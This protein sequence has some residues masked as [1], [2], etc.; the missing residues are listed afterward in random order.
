MPCSVWNQLTLPRTVERMSVQHQMPGAKVKPILLL[1]LELKVSLF[2]TILQ[3]EAQNCIIGQVSHW[4]FFF[5]CELRGL[6]R[7][8]Y[9]AIILSRRTYTK[10]WIHEWR[11]FFY[12]IYKTVVSRQIFVDIFFSNISR[13]TYRWFQYRSVIATH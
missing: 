10:P 12:Q 9:F 5:K 1:L 6:K 11:N 8:Y 4:L 13:F 7:V 2:C 3:Y